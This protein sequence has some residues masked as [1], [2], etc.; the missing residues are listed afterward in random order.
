MMPHQQHRIFP[1][2]TP[3]CTLF[4]VAAGLAI[5]LLFQ[6]REAARFLLGGTA[7]P[8]NVE[9]VRALAWLRRPARHTA[10]SILADAE[11]RALALLVRLPLAGRLRDA[12]CQLRLLCPLSTRGDRPT[13]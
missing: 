10:V 9:H 7:L 13:C 5:P 1:T 11:Q 4:S 12:I 2:L 8:T 3:V 6:P